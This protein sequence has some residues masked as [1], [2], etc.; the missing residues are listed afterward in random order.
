MGSIDIGHNRHWYIHF[1]SH[2]DNEVFQVIKLLQL[3]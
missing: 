1:N 2:Q 3:Q